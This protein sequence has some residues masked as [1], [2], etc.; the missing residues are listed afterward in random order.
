MKQPMVRSLTLNQL[1]DRIEIIDHYI[2][3]ALAYRMRFSRNVGALKIATGQPIVRSPKEDDRLAM[4]MKHGADLGLNP[5]FVKSVF[6]SIINESCK[7]QTMQL[8]GEHEVLPN[9]KNEDAWYA[10]LRKRLKALTAL[11]ADSYE[12][13]YSTGFFS[14]GASYDHEHSKII[15]MIEAAPKGGIALDL[16]CA[17][18]R[19]ARMLSNHHKFTKVIGLDFS[20]DMIR[21][22]N[23][24]RQEMESKKAQ[25]TLSFKVA[26]L[27]ERLD[28]PDDSVSLVVMN[29]GT[30]SDIRNFKKLIKEVERVLMPGGKF[31]FSFYNKNALLY[32]WHFLPWEPSLAAELNH[33]MV[34]LDV[35]VKDRFF[36]VF[37]KAYTVPEV[38]DFF[39]N[40][41]TM[42]GLETFPTVGPILPNLLFDWGKD[43]TAVEVPEETFDNKDPKERRGFAKIGRPGGAIIGLDEHLK[44]RHLGAY[45][46]VTGTKKG[47]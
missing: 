8:Q 24:K 11:V 27:E 41:L 21:V 23:Q 17:T 33:D 34:C 36:T 13:N 10:H 28:V 3:A 38:C 43:H 5:H 7:Q 29:F 16:G 39:L 19:V 6:Y 12:E 32:T 46:V 44:D 31:F 15:S 18:G 2:A 40:N 25:K 42:D 30:A 9:I 26:D 37:A 14:S 45:I 22:A 4:V 1:G 20:E 35:H 47:P